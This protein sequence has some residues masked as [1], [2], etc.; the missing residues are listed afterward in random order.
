MADRPALHDGRR[1]AA[2]GETLVRSQR[3]ALSIRAVVSHLG[4]ANPPYR[5]HPQ[6]HPRTS[7][8]SVPTFRTCRIRV[9]LTPLNVTLARSSVTLACGSFPKLPE[10]TTWHA[11]PTRIR[12]SVVRC[13]Q[14]WPAGDTS[15]M[16]DWFVVQLGGSA[17]RSAVEA[18]A[19]AKAN[20][21]S[22]QWSPSF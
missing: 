13:S 8:S 15:A 5:R 16:I 1:T 12:L 11:P 7:P 9:T 10:C 20:Q 19:D 4:L 17:R 3:R 14:E 21:H 6:R 22:Q 18:S 2:F